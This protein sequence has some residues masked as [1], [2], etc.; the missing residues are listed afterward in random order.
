MVE[1]I[2]TY[3]RHHTEGELYV[4]GELI[5]LTLEHPWRD[6]KK[7]I[8]C[9]PEGEYRLS[10]F[11]SIKHPNTYHV[12]N[13]P[14]RTGILFHVGNGLGD[15]HGCIL[16]GTEFAATGIR[17]LY[18]KVGFKQFMTAMKG[19]ETDRILITEEE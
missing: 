12:D 17:I 4:D 7:G 2:R 13:V 8:S 3:C 5:C 16:T 1:L 9:V 6:N 10:K 15:T 14:D 11:E 19:R 18:S